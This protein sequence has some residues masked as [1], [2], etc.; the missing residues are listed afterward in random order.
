M[1]EKVLKQQATAEVAHRIH[2][3]LEK[4]ICETE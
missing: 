3:E 4:K 1:N 2:V